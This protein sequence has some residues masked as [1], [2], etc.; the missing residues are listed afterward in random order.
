M[1]SKIHRTQ[2]HKAG[3]VVPRLKADQ[4]VLDARLV[5]FDHILV[6]VWVV[7]PDVPLSAAIWDCPKTKG[8]R[9]GIWALE[10]KI[11]EKEFGRI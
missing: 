8:W 4:C 10:L 6:H 11:Q 7:L 5:V 9:E 2:I 1:M 3:E